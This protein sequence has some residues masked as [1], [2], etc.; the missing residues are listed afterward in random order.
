MS[1]TTS[2]FGGEKGG[3]DK[4]EP[5]NTAKFEAYVQ[6]RRQEMEEKKA[7]EENKFQEEIQRFVK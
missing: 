1:L 2:A 3:G 4:A 7:N 5:A 6:H